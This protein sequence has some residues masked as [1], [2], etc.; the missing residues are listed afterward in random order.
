MQLARYVD[1]E[2]LE[3]YSGNSFFYRRIIYNSE[4]RYFLS[5]WCSECS[6]NIVRGTNEQKNSKFNK[7][8]II[9]K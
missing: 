9:S 7:N 6:S 3:Q 5:Y 1:T 2:Q 4:R 8:L